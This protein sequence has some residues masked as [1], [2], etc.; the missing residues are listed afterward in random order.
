[1][2]YKNGTDKRFLVLLQNQENKLYRIKRNHEYKIIVKKL[3]PELGYNS[4]DAAVNGMP[5]N[6]PWIAVE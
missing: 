1:M 6:N 5:A 4:F 2:T 3:N